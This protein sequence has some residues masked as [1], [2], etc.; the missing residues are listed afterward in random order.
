LAIRECAEAQG[1]TE[2][3]CCG[4]PTR[5]IG[6]A[7]TASTLKLAHCDRCDRHQW[8]QDG[9]EVSLAHVMG[10]A[11]RQWNRKPVRA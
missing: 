2:R 11:A 5:D 1:M 7:L 6:I 4:R 3:I 10:S 9:A 8:S